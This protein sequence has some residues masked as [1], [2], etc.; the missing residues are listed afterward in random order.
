MKVEH[1]EFEIEIL[2]DPQYSTASVDNLIKYRFEYSEGEENKERINPA[3]KH[4]IQV[5]DKLTGIEISSA[6]IC[7][8]GGATT[9]HEKSYFIDN[10]KIW[11][12]VCDK[13]YCLNLP[14]LEIEWF[15]RIDYATNFSINQFRDDFIIHGELGIICINR[16]GDIKWRFGGRD[17]FVSENGE[18]NFQIID[19][20]IKVKDWGGFEYKIDENGKELK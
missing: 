20:Q 11:I 1:Q 5:K 4:G 14:E 7:E 13:I 6:I 16:N 9:I 19:N 2:D 10:E 8:Q 17:I 15:R 3:S 12:C 18:A